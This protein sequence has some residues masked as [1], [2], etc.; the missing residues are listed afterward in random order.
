LLDLALLEVRL[1]NL[2][3]RRVDVVTP[4]G[5]REPLRSVALREAVGV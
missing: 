4:D 2:L 1:E 5:L 3:G